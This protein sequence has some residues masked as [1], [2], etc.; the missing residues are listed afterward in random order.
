MPKK[1]LLINDL[2]L[3]IAAVITFLGAEHYL[4]E[5]G[6][7]SF[8]WLIGL[9]GVAFMI[10]SAEFD[11]AIPTQIINKKI[12]LTLSHIFIFICLKIYLD[13]YLE[14]YWWVLLLAGVLIINKSYVVANWI[15]KKIKK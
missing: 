10:W 4:V 13:P 3:S 11:K 6:Y 5:N 7:T 15:N 9:I 1:K 8:A 2:F 12:I 14:Q